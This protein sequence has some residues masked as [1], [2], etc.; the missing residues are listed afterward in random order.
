MSWVWIFLRCMEKSNIVNQKHTEQFLYCQFAGNYW[1]NI[2]STQLNII[3]TR[4]ILS[5][6]ES[7]FHPDDSFVHQFISIFHEIYNAFDANHSLELRG[8]FLDIFKAFDRVW[9][10]RL[11][12]KINPFSAN[13]PLRYT[14]KTSQNLKFYDF[15][16]G[17]E[18]GHWLKMD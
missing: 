11:F 4:N 8:V 15:W 5:S 17:M 10:G 9:H 18:V 16:G 13:V 7:G 2:C 6:H 3:D 12:C 1:K 14:L